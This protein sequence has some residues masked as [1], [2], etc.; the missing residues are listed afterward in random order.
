[1]R[2]ALAMDGAQSEGLYDLRVFTGSPLVV[3]AN[4]YTPPKVM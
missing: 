1:M 3:A 2:I 4:Q